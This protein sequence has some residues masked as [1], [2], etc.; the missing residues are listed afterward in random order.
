MFLLW[1]QLDTPLIILFFHLLV[2]TVQLKYSWHRIGLAGMET[3]NFAFFQQTPYCSQWW[4]MR[5]LTTEYK[6]AMK[7]MTMKLIPEARAAFK[8]FFD[9]DMKILPEARQASKR[10][11]EGRSPPFLQSPQSPE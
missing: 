3:R 11:L 7:I 8:S 2:C 5:E 9:D 1:I 10:G 6:C 4:A